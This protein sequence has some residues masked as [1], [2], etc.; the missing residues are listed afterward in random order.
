[1][2]QRAL[3]LVLLLICVPPQRAVA[4]VGSDAHALADQ[5]NPIN[6]ALGPLN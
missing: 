5:L 1:M 2:K 4:D 3:L 6:V